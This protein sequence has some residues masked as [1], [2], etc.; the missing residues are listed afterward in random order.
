[1]SLCVLCVKFFEKFSL[2]LKKC[3]SLYG[4]SFFIN[5]IREYQMQGLT[6]EEGREESMEGEKL[7]I[8]KNLLSEGSTLEFLHRITGLSLEK[9]KEIL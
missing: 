4:Y 7:L 8:A 9:I 3:E 1:L 5:K 2:I 6:L